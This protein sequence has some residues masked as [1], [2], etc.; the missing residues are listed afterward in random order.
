MTRIVAGLLLVFGCSCTGSTK[1]PTDGQF[2]RKSIE[3]WDSARREAEARHER[4]EMRELLRSHGHRVCEE[5][6]VGTEWKE[7]CNSCRCYPGGVRGCTMLYCNKP[8]EGRHPP[9]ERI[10]PRPEPGKRLHSPRSD[11]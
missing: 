10:L 2:V 1:S 5:G 11:G 7:D 9:A 6:E 4:A 3:R 8:G